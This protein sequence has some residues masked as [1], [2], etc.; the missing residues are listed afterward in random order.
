MA[1]DSWR[2]HGQLIRPGGEIRRGTVTVAG[3]QIVSLDDEDAPRPDPGSPVLPVPPD[4]F[5]GPGLI[6]LH[7]HGA[8]GSDFMAAQA[9]GARRIT[10]CTARH[11]SS[12]IPGLSRRTMQFRESSCGDWQNSEVVGSHL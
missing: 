3:G 12:R 8:E 4:S 2:I 7:M 9:E 5:V 1:G 6:D 10:A 11:G